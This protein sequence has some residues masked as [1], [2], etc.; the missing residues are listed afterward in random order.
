MAGTD[1]KKLPDLTGVRVKV[2]ETGI[3]KKI[4]ELKGD[5]IIVAVD[6]VAYTKKMFDDERLLLKLLDVERLLSK[7]LL[8][9]VG[10]EV[11]RLLN[12]LLSVERPLSK[13][14]VRG[15]LL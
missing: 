11:L 1:R 14:P 4:D 10:V 12:E 13:R 7:R 8:R 6:G 15:V 3:E 9:C 2:E 5:D